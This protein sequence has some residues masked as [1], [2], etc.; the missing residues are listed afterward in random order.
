MRRRLLRILVPLALVAVAGYLVHRLTRPAPIPVA[1]AT[2]ERGSVVA[3]VAN[4]R[5]GTIK[6]CRRARLAPLTSGRIVRLPIREGDRVRKGALLLEL[7]SDDLRAQL[8][9]AR[10]ERARARAEVE[11]ACIDAAFAEREA[12]RT[13]RL[14]RDDVTGEGQLD[15][16][17]SA[18][19]AARAAC[20]AARAAAEAAS[21]RVDAA[22]A[23]LERTVL[24]AP[25]DGVVAELNGELGEVVTPSPPGIPTPPAVDLIEEHCLYVL[26]PLDEVDAPRVE[27]GQTAR[28][29]LDAYPG[30]AFPGHVR[31]VA[32]YV[33]DR[34]KQARTIDIE[35]ALDDP[36]AIPGLVPGYSADVEVLLD[37]REEVLR[38]PTEALIDGERVLVVRGDRLVARRVTTGLANWDWTEIVSGVEEGD[39]VVTSLDRTGVEEGA[40]VRVEAASGP[41]P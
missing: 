4:T 2:V 17:R 11:R 19:D 7:W 21:A 37:T 5:A 3:S 9:A 30:R 32:P 8:A 29:T 40:L 36:D 12:Q 13:E 10:A 31:R 1:V 38:V 41:A 16:A 33:L 28:V 34:E 6:A 27:V 15:R 35:V 14:A 18:R 26:A 22:T 20:A 24:R 39:L 23:A 25:F